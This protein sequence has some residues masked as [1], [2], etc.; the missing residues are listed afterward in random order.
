VTRLSGA[1]LTLL[2]AAVCGYPLLPLGE[3]AL[4]VYY[5]AVAAFAVLTGWVALAVARPVRRAGV[6]YLL[7]GYTLWVL[8]DGLWSLEAYWW[9][10]DTYP[11]PSDALYL[12]GYAFLVA[13][14]EALV[15]TRGRNRD[16]TA[17]LDAVIAATGVAVPAAVFVI[18]PAAVDSAVSTLGKVVSSAY[19]VGDILI[20][21]VLVR[22]LVTSGTRSWSSVAMTGS[23]VATFAADVWWNGLV[24]SGDVGSTV[25]LDV[26]WLA[27]YVLL[28]AGLLHRSMPALADPPPLREQQASVGRL[29]LL[30][31]ASLLP[32]LTLL[33]AGLSGARI[34]WAVLSVGGAVLT[35]LVVIRMAGLLEKVREQ[36]VQLAAL[37]HRDGLTG[38]PNRRTWDHELSR[39]CAAARDRDEPL[40]VAILD[41]DHFKSFNDRFG[42]PA[43]DRLLEQAVTA[44]TAALGSQGLLARY[45]GEEFTVL[46]PATELADAVRVLERLR[47]ATPGG[48][49]FSAGVARWEPGS[50]PGEALQAADTALY[51]AKRAGRDRITA[52]GLPDVDVLP[53]HLRGLTVLLQPIVDAGTGAVIGHEALSRFAHEADVVKVFTE[54]HRDGIGDLLEASALVAALAA[55]GRPAGTEL[56]V[57]VSADALRSDRFW[58]L[59]PADLRGVVVE[60]LEDRDATDWHALRPQLDTLLRRGARLAVDD[61][62]AGAG[63][64]NRL[65]EIRPTVVKIDRAVVAGCAGDETRRRLIQVVVDLAHAGGAVV[66]A[67][68]IEELDDL[69]ALTGLGVDLVQGFLL[70][71]PG[72][73][74]VR[75]AGPL[76]DAVP[77]GA[78]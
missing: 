32:A 29:S 13:G 60:L 59:V 68:G 24:I 50:E 47:R 51:E 15:R 5:D 27:G 56:F 66:C 2:V 9:E 55:P 62:G 44:W 71:R 42:H 43:G 16:R 45:G 4:L 11:A 26:L 12:A 65:L 67:E 34:P 19:P 41:L 21:A 61:L 37:A 64:L 14:V 6:T 33:G 70:G 74:W 10:L 20:L 72:D 52:A 57:N 63:D 25:P 3:T 40:S 48:Q 49:T 46:M 31:V 77:A 69:T 35:I 28:A 8:G 53:P 1:V 39:A 22:L 7:A 23:V 36:A 76:A 17:L 18:A 54:A 58:T 73:R 30:T 78:R 75:T 38:A